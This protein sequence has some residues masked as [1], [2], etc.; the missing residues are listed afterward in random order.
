[1]VLGII[2]T[3]LSSISLLVAGAAFLVSRPPC[4]VRVSEIMVGGVTGPHDIHAGVQ[5]T[6][7]NGPRPTGLLKIVMKYGEAHVH[8]HDA[9]GVFTV[10]A[11]AA[12]EVRQLSLAND[13]R[14]GAAA[15]AE[16]GDRGPCERVTVTDARGREHVILPDKQKRISSWR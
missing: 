10:I 12:G 13:G 3:S 15:L 2:G 9:N 11:L 5:L 16:V 14:S 4:L 1:M 8:A 7:A 6:F